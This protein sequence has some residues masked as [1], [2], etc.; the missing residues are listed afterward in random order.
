MASFQDILVS[1][2][3][4]VIPSGFAAAGHAGVGSGDNQNSKV[5]PPPP[6]YKHSSF[7]RQDA[8]SAIQTTVS[9]R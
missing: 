7:Y 1:R 6:T 3:Q 9:E 2:Y 4:K 8:I 5:K